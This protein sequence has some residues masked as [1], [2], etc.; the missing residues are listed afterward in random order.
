M[1][2]RTYG[3]IFD[4]RFGGRAKNRY[5]MTLEIVSGLDLGYVLHQ[6]SSR[7]RL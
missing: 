4:F 6:F 5:E 3:R 7:T 2:G 1:L